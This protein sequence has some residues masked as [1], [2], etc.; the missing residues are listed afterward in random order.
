[1]IIV[2]GRLELMVYYDFRW[3]N[4]KQSILELLFL[5]LRQLLNLIHKSLFRQHRLFRGFGLVE[6]ISL[7]LSGYLVLSVGGVLVLG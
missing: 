1:M 3:W 5:L 7:I 6:V 2:K 4:L